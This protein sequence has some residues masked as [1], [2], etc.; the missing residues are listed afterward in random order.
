MEVSVCSCVWDGEFVAVASCF[1][2]SMAYRAGDGNC[3]LIV[4][5]FVHG[6]KFVSL[7]S[8]AE[9]FESKVLDDVRGA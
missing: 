2:V 9:F 8:S 1:S 3:N 7:S 4:V 6:D 5:H